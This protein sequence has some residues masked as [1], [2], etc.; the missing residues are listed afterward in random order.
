M[1][2]F[3]EVLCR[4]IYAEKLS[5]YIEVSS[6]S[7]LNAKVTFFRNKMIAVFEDLYNISQHAIQVLHAARETISCGPRPDL[8]QNDIFCLRVRPEDLSFKFRS[9]TS[10]ARI[11]WQWYLHLGKWTN[12]NKKCK[13][14]C[15]ANEPLR[16]LVR[17]SKTQFQIEIKYISES[18]KFSVILIKNFILLQS[19]FLLIFFYK[20]H[21]IRKIYLLILQQ[22][23]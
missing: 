8:M 10:V 19:S 23:L 11:T 13:W 3:P 17:E 1:L 4:S 9:I 18:I 2:K 14:T 5:Y 22:A 12:T 15:W 16:N 6:Y 20:Y 21:W 7:L